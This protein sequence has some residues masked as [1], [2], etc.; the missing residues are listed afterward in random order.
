MSGGVDSSVAALLLKE[1]GYDVVGIFLRTGV[2]E[3]QR[4]DQRH[5]GCCSALDARD[6]RHV[7]DRLDI[8]CYS[9]DFAA[10]FRQVMDY[11]ADEYVRGR[12]PNPCVVCNSQIKF[13]RLWDLARS[14]GA[15]YLATGHYARTATIAGRTSLRRAVDV[16]KDQT[17]VLFGIPGQLLP[18][19]RFP[20]G[21][22]TKGE[23]RDRAR[24]AGLGVAEKAESQDICF[25]PDGDAAAFVRRERPMA[26]RPGLFVDTAG[27]VLGEHAGAAQFT[28]GQRKRL[29]LDRSTLRGQRRFVLDIVPAEGKVV[30]GAEDEGQVHSLVAENCNWMLDPVPRQACLVKWSH[31]SDPVPAC[32]TVTPEGARIDFAAPQFG[33]APGQAVVFYQDDQV[34]GGGWI[35][36][37][38]AA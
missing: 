14:L 13:G 27:R 29:G 32:L 31:R 6:A 28:V 24:R 11:F 3:T 10:E 1:Q 7:A 2:A 22:L 20:V 12:T 36:R 17:Y 34:L 30:L 38:R 5:R 19:L 16:R 26:D 23:V 35:A 4:H 8:P 15:D 33:V 9:L 37:T 21:E 18:H 25:V